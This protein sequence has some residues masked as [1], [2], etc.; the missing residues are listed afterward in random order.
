MKNSVNVDRNSFRFT[1][2]RLCGRKLDFFPVSNRCC[3]ILL[4]FPP[5]SAPSG[6]S[7]RQFLVNIL[8]DV[9]VQDTGFTVSFKFIKFY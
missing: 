4:Y 1:H 2:S 7:R 8:L 9:M 3:L 5:H 6:V